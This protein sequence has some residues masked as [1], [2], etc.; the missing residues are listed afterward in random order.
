MPGNDYVYL[1]AK[2]DGE[3]IETNLYYA[4]ISNIIT[5]TPSAGFGAIKLNNKPA[6]TFDK[7]TKLI[8]FT[9]TPELSIPDLSESLVTS[10]GVQLKNTRFIFKYRKGFEVHKYSKWQNSCN[11]KD[12]DLCSS[13]ERKLR[14]WLNTRE[15]PTMK[16][17]IGEFP[18]YEE[19]IWKTK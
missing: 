8:T 7:K 18:Q 13:C 15:I 3:E 6:G 19:E 5:V 11:V 1:A 10:L 17:I 12:F 16:E 2:K 14:E 9:T 4:P